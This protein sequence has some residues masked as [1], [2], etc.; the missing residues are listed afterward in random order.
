M[1]TRRAAYRVLVEKPVGRRPL[2]IPRRRWEDNIK[3]D[4]REVRWGHI[5][6]LSGLECGQVVGCCECGYELRVL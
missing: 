2:G 1:G 4:L 3:I 5:L 6:D